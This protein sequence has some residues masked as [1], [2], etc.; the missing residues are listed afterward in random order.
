MANLQIDQIMPTRV[1]P[2]KLPYLSNSRI[3]P[4]LTSQIYKVLLV[5][6]REKIAIKYKDADIAIKIFKNKGFS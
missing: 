1:D 5:R 3:F 6:I 4:W 2:E